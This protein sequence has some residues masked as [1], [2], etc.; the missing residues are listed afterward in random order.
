MNL[1]ERRTFIPLR[2]PPDDGA[3]A[4]GPSPGAGTSPDRH[5][6][7]APPPTATDIIC[8]LSDDSHTRRV[9]E[10]ASFEPR[11]SPFGCP[12]ADGAGRAAPL[13][14]ATAAAA[15]AAAAAAAAEEGVVTRCRCRRGVT[16][17]AR[18]RV[19]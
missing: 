11:V 16:M 5:P 9:A 18:R 3:G 2:R 14:R 10:L 7:P 8:L 13:F 6:A 15:V 4:G 19:T 12:T 17:F 1:G